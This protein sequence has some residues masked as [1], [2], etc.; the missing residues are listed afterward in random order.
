MMTARRRCAK[1]LI[2]AEDEEVEADGHNPFSFREFLRCKNQDQDQDQTHQNANQEEEGKKWAWSF[3]SATAESSTSSHCT[4]EEEEEEAGTRF[5]CK[6]AADHR[7][8][9]AETSEGK[10]TF[11][12][13]PDASCR[14]DNIQQL[15]EEN[16][17]LRK[18]IRELSR[19]TEADQR[20]VAQLTEELVQ[21]RT[22]EV[23][24]A[25]DLERMVQ[26][27]EQNLCLMTKRALKAENSLSKL[28]A[29]LQQLQAQVEAYRL[30]NQSLKLA[31]SEV[32]ATMKD[33][34]K[35][36]SECL[37]KTASHAHSSIQQLMGEAESLRLVSQLLQSIDKISNL[38]PQS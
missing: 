20:R 35:M 34:A 13:E 3:Q 8:G 21:R 18:T 31:E 25:Q 14:S 6:P 27:V 16:L 1:T 24:E 2:I 11:S 28:K 10:E 37:S 30:E 23:K 9:G 19:K 36:A 4:E 7:G 15:K 22:Q 26:S 17:L 38:D 12:E 33:K 32:V 5:S 29:E